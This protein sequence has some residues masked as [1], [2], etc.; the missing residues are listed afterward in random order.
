MPH[1]YG[2]VPLETPDFIKDCKGNPM[3]IKQAILARAPEGANVTSLKWHKD[4]PIVKVTVEGPAGRAFLETLQA[5]P[6]VELVDTGP[7]S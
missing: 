6:I 7:I 5:N 3:C 2:L 4:D 1:W